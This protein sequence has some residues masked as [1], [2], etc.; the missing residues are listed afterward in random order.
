[1]RRKEQN[2]RERG[3]RQKEREDKKPTAMHIYKKKAQFQT[4]S[5]S[6]NLDRTYIYIYIITYQNTQIDLFKVTIR[7]SP[8]T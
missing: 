5:K 4:I 8:T 7:T 6:R 3:K 1:M 2:R